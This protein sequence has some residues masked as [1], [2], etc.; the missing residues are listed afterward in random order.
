MTYWFRSRRL[1]KTGALIVCRNAIWKNTQVFSPPSIV[2]VPKERG[3]LAICNVITLLEETTNSDFIYLSHGLWNLLFS[4]GNIYLTLKESTQDK[5]CMSQR[6]FVHIPSGRCQ[7]EGINLARCFLSISIS[8]R[9]SFVYCSLPWTLPH[10]KIQ[11]AG[12]SYV[13]GRW[14]QLSD[15]I[16]STCV[17]LLFWG[18]CADLIDNPCQYINETMTA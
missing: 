12:A 2:W 11:A 7:Y 16:A 13:I 14:V 15:W 17:F 9:S 4:R 1:W 5:A 10:H 3:N 18:K 6:D 8:V